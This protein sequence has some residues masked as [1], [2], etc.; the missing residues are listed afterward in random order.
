MSRRHC[1]TSGFADAPAPTGDYGPD[2]HIET[3]LLGLGSGALLSAVQNLFIAPLWM[4]LVW[5]VHA[6]LVMLEWAF[7]IDLLDSPATG[8][9]GRGL[10]QA[11]SALTYPWLALGLAVASVFALY[12]GLVRRRISETVGHA[13]LMAAMMVGGMAVIADPVGTVGALGAGANQASLGTL[14]VASSGTP[15]NPAGALGESMDGVFTATIEGPWCYLEF[16]NVGWCRD[17]SRL[18][19][20]LKSTANQLAVAELARVGCPAS[21]LA[22]G[23]CVAQGSGPA[24][25]LE[26]SAELVREAHTNGAIFLAFPA[27]EP[28]RN[29]I[30][31]SGSL[32][33]AVCGSSEATECKGPSAAEALFRT[34]SGTW[35]RVG[36]LLLILAG[37]LG[38]LLLLGFIGMRLLAAAILSLLYLLLTPGLVLAPAF[39]ESERALFRRWAGHLL[40]AVASKLIFSFLLGVVLAA[41][42]VLSSLTALGWWTQWLLLSAFWWTAYARRHQALGLAHG[43]LGRERE[44]APRRRRHRLSDVFS[45]PGRVR[46]KGRAVQERLGHRLPDLAAAGRVS[47]STQPSPSS[48]IA[49]GVDTQ[50]Q[51]SLEGRRREARSS[52]VDAPRVEQGLAARRAQLER[53]EGESDRAVATQRPRRRM[54]LAHRAGRVRAEIEQEQQ[55]LEEARRLTAAGRGN[56]SSAPAAGRRDLRAQSALLDRQAGLPRAGERRDKAERRD[57]AALSALAGLGRRQYEGLSPA[58]QRSARL[59]IDR[60]LAHRSRLRGLD[61]TSASGTAPPQAGPPPAGGDGHAVPRRSPAGWVTG[62]GVRGSR[63]AGTRGSPDQEESAV[64]RDV[65]EVAARRKRQLGFGRE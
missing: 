22:S 13:V 14:A 23:S 27:N 15:A 10:Q 12:N 3:G 39:G 52:L 28:A 31:E 56:G 19:S 37:V 64:M 38:M 20:R 50:A 36:G 42:T 9:L 24:S 35:P 29:S 62:G 46:E 17:P 7:T 60:E 48:G 2:V 8:G 65:R 55:R 26:H 4:A 1:E 57:Y 58:R 61:E 40:G 5:S 32:L 47:Q 33:R 44:E 34:D 18:E 41:G 21:P 49:E 53:I 11:Q 16:G 43:A 25:L 59:E 6:L 45:T 63:T 51:R 54:E 30:S